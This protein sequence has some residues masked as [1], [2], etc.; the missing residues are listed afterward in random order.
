MTIGVSF[1]LFDTLFELDKDVPT[2]GAAL[3]ERGYPCAPSVEAIWNSP[4]FDGRRTH[5]PKRETYEAWRHRCI[6]HLAALC[7]A[8]AG[9]APNL[10]TEL[11]AL[12][13]T[14]TVRRT[15]QASALLAA[16]HV[17]DTTTCLLSNW[18]YPLRPYLA[19][20]SLPLDLPAIVSAEIGYRK[21]HPEAFAHAR[22]ILQVAPERH[23]HVGDDWR[24]DVLGAIQSGAWAL[25]LTDTE[26][27]SLP[28][29]IV[30]VRPED[31]ASRLSALIAMIGQS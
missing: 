19:M 7:G 4:G 16:A 30:A 13:Q 29:R 8:P 20:A 21:P 28:S 26:P 12:D 5:D 11:I 25:W 22:A 31:A 24:A 17:G 6:T 9:T 15:G 27:Q 18:D 1:D 23:I 3:T 10:A 14:W 2:I